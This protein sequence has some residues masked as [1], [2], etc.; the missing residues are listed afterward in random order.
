MRIGFTLPQMGPVAR[1]AHEAGRFAKE[2]EALG[3]DSLW[4]GD[5]LLA[6]VE[7]TVGYGGGDSVPDTFRTVLDPFALMA[8]AATTT[9]RAEIGANILQAP[10]YAPA[11][12]ARSLTTIDLISGGRLLPG[13]GT[14]WSPE[15]YQ[16]A[17][18]P[19]KERGARLDEALDALE[20]WWTTDPV[21]FEGAY[22]RIPATYVGLK[23]VR[24]PRPPIYL[25][26]FA[27]AAMRRVAR[28][29]DGWLPV[30]QP[31]SGPFTPDA[32]NVP[33]AEVRRLAAEAGRDP[34]GLGMVLRVYPTTEATL[35]EVVGAIT[36]AGRETDVDHCFVELMNIAHDVDHALELVRTVLDRAR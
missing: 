25:A 30:V 19:M 16:A 7:P 10:W 14:G 8:V 18:V 4:V 26:G 27:P 3:A 29:A 21:E 36:G 24:R 34:S 23:P 33:M 35:D 22:T 13:F 15:E 5:R 6:P 11:L 32:V 1:Q 31:G 9:E 20:A 12:L 2:A 28:R 17:G